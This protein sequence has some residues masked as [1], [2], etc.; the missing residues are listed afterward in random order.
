MMMM[1][2]KCQ[3]AQLNPRVIHTHSVVHKGGPLSYANSTIGNEWVPKTIPNN[4]VN[5]YFLNCNQHFG[6]FKP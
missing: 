2:M 4:A 6:N 1:M 5:I 3:L